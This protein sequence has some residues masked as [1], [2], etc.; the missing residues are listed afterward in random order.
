MNEFII[1]KVNNN[2]YDRFLLC[3]TFESIANYKSSIESSPLITNQTGKMLIDQLLVTGN[4]PNRF[5]SCD[6]ING[7]L[8]FTTAKNVQISNIFK[9]ITV[10]WLNCHYMYVDHSILTESQ[11]R[12]IRDCI[13]F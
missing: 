9:S 3:L 6:Y 13:P 7:I 12:C 4:G 8:D 11:R 10:K 1:H 5:I 2:G